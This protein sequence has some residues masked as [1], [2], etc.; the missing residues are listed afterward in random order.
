MAQAERRTD[1]RNSVDLRILTF[2]V[3]GLR[4]NVKR[5]ALFRFFHAQY[6]SHVIVL[7]ETHSKAC[8]EA[9][10][11]TEWGAEI[12][13]A[14]GITSNECGV[15]VLM[16]GAFNGT[17]TPAYR[18]IDGRM[19]IINLEIEAV[20]IILF[21]IYAPTQGHAR[22]QKKFLHSLQHQLRHMSPDASQYIVLCGDFNVHMSKLDTDSYRF[23]RSA[24]S[25]LLENVLTEFRLKD[26]WRF[27][28]PLSRQFTWRRLTPL[29]QSRIDYVLASKHLVSNHAVKNIDIHSGILS[30]HSMVDLEICLYYSERGPGLWRFN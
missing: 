22:D 18:D 1:N 10:W 4:Q 12:F 23:K 20:K 26:V 7:Q 13:F 17:A 14:H 15:S 21:G 30:D 9:Y 8:D 6:P 16:P 2:N 27:H 11:K 19:L 25:R 28:H 24:S 29:Q 3:R 5:R